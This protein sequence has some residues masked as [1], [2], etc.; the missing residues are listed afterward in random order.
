MDSKIV[1]LTVIVIAAS[2]CADQQ[3]DGTGLVVE[4]FS[5]VDNTLNPDQET[6]IETTIVNYNEAPTTLKSE[7][8][9]IYNTGQLTV[10]DK[11]CNP[12]EIGESRRNL[13]PTMACSWTLEAPG[14]EF[15]R[16]F[17]S[18]PAS[19]NLG[20]SYDSTLENTESVRIMFQDME[21]IEESSEITRTFSNGDLTAEISAQSPVAVENPQ[22]LNLEV[23]NSGQ[24][25]V[26]GSYSFD[27]DPNILT[28]CPPELEPIQGDAQ[29]NCVLNADSTGA[30]N[31]FA[32]ISYKYERSYSKTIEVVN[33]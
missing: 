28:S 15:V 32:S 16:G 14:D 22:S 10:E 21:E 29:I 9:E 4:D 18:K 23:S 27:F 5:V 17:E 33:N 2:G 8:V 7:N 1:L 31:L 12:S 6:R 13:N 24:G 25:S 19:F 26:D 3:Q 20:L 11:I 30:R